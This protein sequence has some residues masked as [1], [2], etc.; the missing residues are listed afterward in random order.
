MYASGVAGATFLGKAVLTSFLSD[1]KFSV[2]SSQEHEANHLHMGEL[3]SRKLSKDLKKRII[4][5]PIRNMVKD[6]E[7]RHGP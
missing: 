6:M 2:Q 7:Q 4:Q 3:L 1:L 5:T